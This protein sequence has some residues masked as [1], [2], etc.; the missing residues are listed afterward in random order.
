MPKKN[1]N[2]VP[3]YISEGQYKCPYCGSVD[4]PSKYF[5][6]SCEPYCGDCGN[7]PNLKISKEMREL[8]DKLHALIEKEME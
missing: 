1:A 3:Y 2:L 6:E 4:N 7:H 5:S 8:V